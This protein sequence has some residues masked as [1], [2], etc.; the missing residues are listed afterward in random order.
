MINI[1]TALLGAGIA[2]FALPVLAENKDEPEKNPDD[3]T[4]SS[5]RLSQ[6]TADFDN[7]DPGFNLGYS[8]GFRLPEV[9]FLSVE[10]DISSTVIPGENSGG[11]SEP[12]V[13]NN[14]DGGGGILDPILGGGGSD[15][16]GNSS[17]GGGK[18]T[19]SNNELLL[20]TL[21]IFGRIETPRS[22]SNR[23]FGTARFGYSYVDSSIPELIEDGRG[24]GSWGVGVGY[25]YG[26][27]GRVELNFTQVAQDL[28]YLALGIS[29]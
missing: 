20:N 15:G 27:D 17:S 28:Q 10:L 24:G 21:G 23:F 16:G 12:I 7:L 8:L 13:N 6:A 25:R 4:Y 19:R 11:V 18:N 3:P 22:L 26:N 9:E 14:D 2:V 5:F 1:R 29:F